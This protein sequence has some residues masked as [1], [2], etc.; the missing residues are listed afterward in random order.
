MKK[1]SAPTTIWDELAAWAEFL[2]DWQRFIVSHAVRDGT[3]TPE[4]VEDVYRLFLRHGRLDEG[5]ESLPQIPTTVTGRASAG[6]SAPPVLKELRSLANVNAIPAS[7][8]LSFG[9]GLTLIYGHNGT[10]KSGFARILAAACFSRSDN[11]IIG[12]IYDDRTFREPASAE[13]EIDKV[14]GVIETLRYAP[15]FEDMD[16]NRIS[17]FDATAARIHLSRKNALTAIFHEWCGIVHFLPYS[18]FN[19]RSNAVLA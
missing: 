13:I 16:L 18:R 2:P 14:N 1:E 15:G 19:K 10:G 4:H 11:E 3:L 9:N 6:A 5:V 8:A 12:N 17:V 7:S